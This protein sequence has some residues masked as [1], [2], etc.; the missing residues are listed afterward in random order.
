VKL[1]SYLYNEAQN[2]CSN[3]NYPVL[4][5][6][7]KSSCEPYTRSVTTLLMQ[8]CI[9]K[10][11]YN[12][13]SPSLLCRSCSIYIVLTVRTGCDYCFSSAFLRF[14]SDWVYSGLFRDVYGEF[15]IQVNEDYLCCRGETTR[16]HAV[17]SQQVLKMK[18][19]HDRLSRRKNNCFMTAFIAQLDL[20]LCL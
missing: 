19:L 2:N 11:Q 3:E 10:A 17:L 4:L 7:L 5:S 14:V 6:L 12:K 16:T 9:L 8:T 13:I 20:S 18:S 15:M 1:L